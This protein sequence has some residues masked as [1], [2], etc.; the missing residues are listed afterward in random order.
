MADSKV[1]ITFSPESSRCLVGLAKIRNQSIQELAQRLMQEV[2]ELER[3]NV[4]FSHE[5]SG[6]LAELAKAEGR[7]VQELAE[8]LMEEAIRDEEDIII[9]ERRAA[10]HDVADAETVDCEDIE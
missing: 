6:R 4:T 9:A 3:V 5:I 8:K 2:L 10:E 7:S 1:S